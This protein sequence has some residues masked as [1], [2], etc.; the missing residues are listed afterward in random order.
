MKY[1]W[2]T[3]ELKVCY[4][5]LLKKDAACRKR[6]DKGRTEAGWRGGVKWEGEKTRS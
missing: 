1:S 6:V 4:H 5:A 3:K 2:H